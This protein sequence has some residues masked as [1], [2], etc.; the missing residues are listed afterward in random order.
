MTRYE[1]Q[2]NKEPIMPSSRRIIRFVALFAT[3][4]GAAAS[5]LVLTAVPPTRAAWLGGVYADGVSFIR[6]QNA[7]GAVAGTHLPSVTPT[8]ASKAAISV[9]LLGLGDLRGPGSRHTFA[10]D[11]VQSGH[12]A[13]IPNAGEID[14]LVGLFGATLRADRPIAAVSGAWWPESAKAAEISAAFPSTDILVP[15]VVRRRGD[16]SYVAI[17][18]TDPHAAAHVTIDLT[19]PNGS[20]ALATVARTIPTGGGT[21]V[22]LAIDRDFQALAG[23]FRGGMRIRSDLPV[24]VA[25][26]VDLHTESYRNGMYAFEGIPAAQ[27]A[28]RLTAPIVRN[29]FN[30]GT[31]AIAFMNPGREAVDVTVTYHGSEYSSNRE[32]KRDTKFVHNGGPVRVPAGASVL[33]YQGY[34][35]TETGPSGLPQGCLGYAVIEVQGG[36]G[37]A[38]VTEAYL[39]GTAAA[40][41]A[42]GRE[43]AAERVS[44][45]LFRRRYGPDEMST[46]LLVTNLGTA[47][48]NVTMDLWPDNCNGSVISSRWS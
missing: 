19:L 28:D 6:V 43:Q 45:P 26:F 4:T 32:C 42:V 36:K 34:G 20:A 5:V 7:I 27:A 39:R 31:T 44:L 21:M 38:I 2:A 24:A 3:L 33:F 29:Y 37:V 30:G 11:G 48:A 1:S 18:N 35:A 15:T 17:Q 46:G 16:S 25:A 41:T 23:E 10:R 8:P 14:G 47:M 12:A 22:D 9:D 13:D 40:Y